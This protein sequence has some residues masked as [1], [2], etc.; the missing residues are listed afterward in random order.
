[1]VILITNKHERLNW[2][3]IPKEYE[4]AV[5]PGFSAYFAEDKNAEFIAQKI[6]IDGSYLHVI[7]IISKASFSIRFN[8]ARP[9]LALK[10]VRKGPYEVVADKKFMMKAGD[11]SFAYYP[12]G[13]GLEVQI[14][15]ELEIIILECP[16]ELVERLSS[17]APRLSQYVC[18]YRLNT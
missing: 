6:S 15:N 1:M 7:R 12:A 5:L 17:F 10:Y 18:A 11:S 8:I 16:G 13:H 9:L 2:V 14:Q 4:Y 3:A